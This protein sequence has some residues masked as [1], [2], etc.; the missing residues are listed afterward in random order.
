M[1]ALKERE[2]VLT[3]VQ[4]LIQSVGYTLSCRTN[5][6]AVGKYHLYTSHAMLNTFFA[7]EEISKNFNTHSVIFL[8]R[9]K[10]TTGLNID[11]RCLFDHPFVLIYGVIRGKMY[12]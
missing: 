3:L 2:N 1:C 5:T 10:R 8:I 7:E 12:N 6:A 4:V 9:I 11:N